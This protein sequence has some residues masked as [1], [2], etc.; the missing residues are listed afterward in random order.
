[1]SVLHVHFGSGPGHARQRRSHLRQ[2]ACTWLMIG[3]A[4]AFAATLAVWYMGMVTVFPIGLLAGTGVLC[5]AACIERVA[6]K[7]LTGLP[8]PGW[9]DT[10]ERFTD[11]GTGAPVAVYYNP[12]CLER[13][14]VRLDR[15]P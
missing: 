15:E 12:T 5:L 4:L 2:P 11:P 13:R 7:P 8:G 1:M 10:G 14:Y 3:S 6:Y 9:Q